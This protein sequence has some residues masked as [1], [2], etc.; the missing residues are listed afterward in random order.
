MIVE[1][2]EHSIFKLMS[3]GQK[4]KS[5]IWLRRDG[6]TEATEAQRASVYGGNWYYRSKTVAKVVQKEV[7]PK[8][9]IKIIIILKS[10]S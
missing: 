1:I 5:L 10:D 9:Y 6:K 8:N 3:S 4:E 2:Q 7:V